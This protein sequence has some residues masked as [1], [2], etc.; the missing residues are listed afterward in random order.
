M[1]NDVKL[2]FPA[3]FAESLSKFREQNAL[4]FVGESPMKYKDVDNNINALIA[5]LEDKGIKQGDKV[6]ILS[7]NMPNW[8]IAYFAITFMGAIAVPLL[9]DF[10]TNEIKNILNHSESKILFVSKNLK[11]KIDNFSND[12]LKTVIDIDNFSSNT[13]KNQSNSFNINNKPQ[14]T[15][16]VNEE[17]LAVL[18]YTSG[19]TGSSKGVMLTHKNICFDCIACK[20]IQAVDKSDRFLSILPL[21][22]TY[23]NTLGMI[24]P[25]FSGACVYYLKKPPVSSV[26]L[27]ALKMVKPTIMLSV[28]LIIEKIYRTNIK[29]AFE[30]SKTTRLLY[31]LPIIRKK[32][33]AIAGNKLMET[34]GGELKFF[35]I[36]GAKVDKTVEQF[37]IEAKFPYAIGYG[38]TETS[39]LIAGTAPKDT[40]LQAIGPTPEGITMKINNPDPKT[41][42]GEVW[43][44]GDNIM[45]GYYKDEKQTKEVI[46]NDG[47]FRTGDLGV[48]DKDGYLSVKGRI[49]NVIVEASGENIYPEEIEAVINNF[50]HVAE[51][52]VVQ[53]KGKLVA[54]V[55]FDLDELERKYRHL[56]NE[57]SHYVEKSVDDLISELLEYVNN[58][59]NKYSQLQLVVA[60]P[61]PFKKTATHKIKRFL[62]T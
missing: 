14:K 27:P 19:T 25:L 48:I 49:K 44:K 59:V 20:K 24:L 37:L 35:G 45:L 39:P 8:G 6:A 5:Y 16:K 23:E 2:T 54:L 11:H 17:D 9:P 32:L 28:P 26:L 55:H 56:R 4:S 7:S 42:E 31:K 51:S 57:V 1:G 41:G 62:Y 13:D 18:I 43:A 36:G 3:M 38:L 40:K 61:E 10:H 46:T 60:Q 52:L 12:S 47:W 30:K 33:N 21:S 53:Q 58:N 15:Y 22:H 50:K 34:F 29:P